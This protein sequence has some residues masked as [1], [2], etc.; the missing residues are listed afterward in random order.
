[1]SLSLRVFFSFLF[2]SFVFLWT[3]QLRFHLSFYFRSGEED[4]EE[5]TSSID[6]TDSGKALHSKKR[7][8][9]TRSKRIRPS[10]E[11]SPSHHDGMT[12][13]QDNLKVFQGASSENLTIADDILFTKL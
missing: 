7:Q 11:K 3:R 10:F 12:S 5:D 6:S 9:S 2:S 4:I 8:K 13:L 1:M